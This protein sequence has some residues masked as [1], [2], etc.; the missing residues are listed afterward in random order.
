MR[1]FLPSRTLRVGDLMVD[2]EGADDAIGWD[3]SVRWDGGLINIYFP[4][5]PCKNRN[6]MECKVYIIPII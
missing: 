1:H 4:G 2:A 5:D 6:C 3:E